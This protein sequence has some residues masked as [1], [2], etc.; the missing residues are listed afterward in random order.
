MRFD[1]FSEKPAN[2]AMINEAIKNGIS[3][4]Y[5][6]DHNYH[7]DANQNPWYHVQIF[8]KPEEGAFKW[9]NHAGVTWTLK[10]IVGPSDVF[11][12]IKLVVGN[13]CPYKNDGHEFA[14]MEWV[15]YLCAICHS[16]SR[17]SNSLNAHS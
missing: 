8:W 12:R 13:D 4:I 1:L 16:Q 17:L 14:M 9:Q 6:I 5:D 2:P 10:A 3:G 7:G 15:S 11:D